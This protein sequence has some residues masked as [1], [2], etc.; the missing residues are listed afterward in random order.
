MLDVQKIGVDSF[1]IRDNHCFINV[2]LCETL[3]QT[4]VCETASYPDK[5]DRATAAMTNCLIGGYETQ[6]A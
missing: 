4:E 3:Q 2:A 1:K 6:S 5:M